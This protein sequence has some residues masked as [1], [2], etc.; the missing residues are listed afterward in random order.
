MLSIPSDLLP[1]LPEGES[2]STRKNLSLQTKD[3]TIIANIFVLLTTAEELQK[4]ADKMNLRILIDTSTKDG[5]VMIK[6]VS[7]IFRWDM[8]LTHAFR[9]A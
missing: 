3:G 1:P 2:E 9:A 4:M 7:S 8:V 5:H 6:M